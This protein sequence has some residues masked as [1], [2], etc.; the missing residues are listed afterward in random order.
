MLPLVGEQRNLTASTVWHAR[1]KCGGGCF[2]GR[3]RGD[4]HRRTGGHAV[5]TARPVFQT[6]RPAAHSD[7]PVIIVQA[8][9]GEERPAAMR[10]DR[11]GSPGS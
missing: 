7:S 9:E 2:F 10:L 6:G 4:N 11:V 1:R 8:M 5:A 3:S